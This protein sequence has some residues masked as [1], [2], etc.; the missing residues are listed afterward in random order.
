MRE[1]PVLKPDWVIKGYYHLYVC[2][3]MELYIRRSNILLETGRT[4]NG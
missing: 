1:S 2:L 4:E 3:Y